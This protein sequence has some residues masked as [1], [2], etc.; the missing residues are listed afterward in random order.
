M[1]TECVGVGAG[2]CT[3]CDMAP[4]PWLW[5]GAF[6]EWL[7]YEASG[8]LRKAYYINTVG[9]HKAMERRGSLCRKE[10]F[11]YPSV[12]CVQR[13]SEVSLVKGHYCCV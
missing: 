5:I 11:R 12:C 8:F 2:V 3:L 1:C 7:F 6:Q 10:H 13:P 4:R 9:P